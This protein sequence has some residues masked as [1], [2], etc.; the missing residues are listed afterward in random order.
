MVAIWLLANAKNGI[1]SYELARLYWRDAEAGVVPV[2]TASALPCNRLAA[3]S[4]SGDVDADETCIGG[5]ARNMHDQ[6][7]QADRGSP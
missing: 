4:C 2:C 6:E 3:A 7:A 1:S 5:K